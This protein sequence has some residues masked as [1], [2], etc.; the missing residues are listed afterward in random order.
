M[1][2]SSCPRGSPASCVPPR[3]NRANPWRTGGFCIGRRLRPHRRW[4]KSPSLSRGGGWKHPADWV[5]RFRKSDGP[6]ISWRQLLVESQTEQ[7][8]RRP[9]KVFT[10]GHREAGAIL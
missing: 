5:G 9:A 3:R 2:V 10:H 6:R 7:R 1:A 4:W 8:R